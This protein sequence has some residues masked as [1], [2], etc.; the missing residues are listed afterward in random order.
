MK[1]QLHFMRKQSIE[2]CHASNFWWKGSTIILVSF[3]SICN[4][5]TVISFIPSSQTS[6]A[7]NSVD[8]EDNAIDSTGKLKFSIRFGSQIFGTSA[9]K[10]NVKKKRPVSMVGYNAN[11]ICDYYN[12]RPLVVGWRLNGL[13]FLLLGTQKHYLLAVLLCDMVFIFQNDV[14]PCF[15]FV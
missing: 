3:L 11:E 15:L 12:R 5:S 7:K 13:S 8:W 4:T 9:T 10:L 1:R 14:L 2:Q 6:I